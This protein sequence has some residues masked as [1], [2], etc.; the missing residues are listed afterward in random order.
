LGLGPDRLALEH[1]VRHLTAVARRLW[2]V[3]ATVRHG[4]VAVAHRAR[5][6]ASG[7]CAALA[8]EGVVLRHAGIAAILD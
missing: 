4:A 1:T 6:G 7:L 8:Q 3:V 5:I 2:A